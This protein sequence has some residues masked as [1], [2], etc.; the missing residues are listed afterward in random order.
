MGFACVFILRS[1]DVEC[2]P[3]NPRAYDFGLQSI[4]VSWSIQGVL[5]GSNVTLQLVG[6]EQASISYFQESVFQI[7]KGP[8]YSRLGK[9]S[10]ANNQPVLT[11]HWLEF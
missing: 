5:T 8:S 2:G 7:G 3:E 10:R 9:A 1:H 11:S 4:S 6:R